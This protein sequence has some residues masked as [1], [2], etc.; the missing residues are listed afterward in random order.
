MTLSAGDWVEVR[1]KEEILATLDKNGRLEEL[2]SGE[3]TEIQAV[4]GVYLLETRQIWAPRIDGPE[5]DGLATA[6]RDLAGFVELGEAIVQSQ[7]IKSLFDAEIDSA[8]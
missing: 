3:L 7:R 4:Y 2:R 1:S 5:C 6:P 8:P